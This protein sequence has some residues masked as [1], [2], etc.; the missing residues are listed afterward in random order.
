MDVVSEDIE[1]G[2]VVDDFGV[3]FGI[4]AHIRK[5]IGEEIRCAVD[6]VAVV[7]VVHVI[8]EVFSVRGEVRGFGRVVR[9]KR[10]PNKK[11]AVWSPLGAR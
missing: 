10:D 3:N 1:H 6:D 2:G 5:D 7:I 9:V 8:H 11:R 4:K